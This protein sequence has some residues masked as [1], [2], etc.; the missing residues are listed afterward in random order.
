MRG[1]DNVDWSIASPRGIDET[2]V[3]ERIRDAS[4]IEP[5]ARSLTE[6]LEAGLQAAVEKSDGESRLN[7]Y[8]SD[9]L[10]KAAERNRSLD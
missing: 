1:E 8:K 4:S 3:H 2:G 9:M 7:L 6:N 10:K 5:N